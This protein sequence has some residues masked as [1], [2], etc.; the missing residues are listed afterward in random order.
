M[1]TGLARRT[2]IKLQES[3]HAGEHSSILPVGLGELAGGFGETPGLTRVDL[4]KC[5]A[6]I[7]QPALEGPV[8]GAGGLI[9]NAG[10]GV[11]GQP[12]EQ[13]PV[14]GLV[15]GET[16]ACPVADAVGVEMVFRD[17]DADGI[18]GH[19]SLGP[20]LVIRSRTA[21]IRSGLKGK[22]RAIIL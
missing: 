12:I 1:R 20:L 21:G 19:L 9:D 5:K 10:A 4:D 17:V 11:P 14:S 18:V 13:C 8:I 6:G 3:T 22:T 7:R 2:G 16:A 15:I